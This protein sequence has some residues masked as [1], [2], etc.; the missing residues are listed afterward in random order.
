[1]AHHHSH[2]TFESNIGRR[3]RRSLLLLLGL[4]VAPL[5]MAQSAVAAKN[6]PIDGGGM[7]TYQF[8]GDAGAA[9]SGTFTGKPF[10]GTYVGGFTAD[11]GTLPPAGECEPATATLRVDGTRGRFVDMTATGNV[12]GKWTSPTYVVTHTFTGRY[13]VDA[14]SSRRLV[15]TDGFMSQLIAN[16]GNA[17]VYAV[18]TD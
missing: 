15:G 4:A 3:R 7:G 2:Q 6:Y 9:V 11:D 5:T 1:M 16:N 17:N 14:S 10:D 12:C 18:A 13:V 8:V